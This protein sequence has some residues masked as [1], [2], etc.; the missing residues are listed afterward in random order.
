MAK[1]YAAIQKRYR[2]ILTR[3]EKEMPAIPTRKS[4]QRAKIAK[5]DAHN[6]RGAAKDP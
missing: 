4:G 1:E 5:S 3:G 6:L 2:S